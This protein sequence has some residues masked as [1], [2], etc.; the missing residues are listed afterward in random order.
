MFT[1]S[2]CLLFSLYVD[3]CLHIS[4]HIF[5]VSLVNT[6]YTRHFQY[7][8]GNYTTCVLHA[9]SSDRNNSDRTRL[10]P[11]GTDHEI[12]KEMTTITS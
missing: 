12:I 11:S 4:T 1:A 3:T 5:Y 6:I 10:D 9:C 7:S 8:C 2:I